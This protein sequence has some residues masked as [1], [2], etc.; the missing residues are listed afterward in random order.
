MDKQ[1]NN[2]YHRK[3]D[4]TV[5]THKATSG[6]RYLMDFINHRPRN[7]F[8]RNVGTRYPRNLTISERIGDPQHPWASSTGPPVRPLNVC[9]VFRPGSG[10]KSVKGRTSEEFSPG[11]EG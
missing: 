4:V 11:N 1:T 3:S 8:L 5:S 7:L 2:R 9:V 6:R 10:G